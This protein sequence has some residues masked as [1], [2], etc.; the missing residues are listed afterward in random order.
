MKKISWFRLLGGGF[1]VSLF[2]LLLEIGFYTYSI[3]Y[4]GWFD[5]TIS[6]FLVLPIVMVALI[7]FQYFL[8]QWNYTQDGL[9]DFFIKKKPQEANFNSL[10]FGRMVVLFPVFFG[11]FLIMMIFQE[12]YREYELAHFGKN[13]VAKVIQKSTYKSRGTKYKLE[14]EFISSDKKWI[15]EITTSESSYNKI[16]LQDT[17]SIR[18]STRNPD[19][20]MLLNAGTDVF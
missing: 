7:L 5:S 9:F 16:N 19:V 10:Q 20:Y 11:S 17:V 2:I 15:A 4:I 1:L 6:F 18:F 13:T 3:I 12:V 8:I 14:C